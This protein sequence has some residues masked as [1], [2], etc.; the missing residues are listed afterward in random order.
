[1]FDKTIGSYNLIYEITLPEGRTRLIDC[2]SPTQ[3]E[4]L[5]VYLKNNGRNQ[6][7]VVGGY[8]ISSADFFISHSLTGAE[9]QIA[10]NIYYSL[11]IYD[12]HE[13]IFIRRE[14]GSQTITL[15]M[16]LSHI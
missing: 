16:I 11:P 12:Y 15:R 9:E 7:H 10:E 8:I 4:D 13:H 14:A 1:M 6:R 5:N 2:F 3:L